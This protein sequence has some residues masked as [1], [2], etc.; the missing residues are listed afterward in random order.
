MLFDAPSEIIFRIIIHISNYSK[1]FSD[2]VWVSLMPPSCSISKSSHRTHVYKI[3]SMGAINGILKQYLYVSKI[4]NVCQNI[5][6]PLMF[7]VFR[8]IDVFMLRL[9]RCRVFRTRTLHFFFIINCSFVCILYQSVWLERLQTQY[10]SCIV[11][12]GLYNT[13][14]R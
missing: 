4:Y 8:L 6:T 1:R 3:A 13:A 2:S 7:F 12:H 5:R 11:R 10:I 14:E 9:R